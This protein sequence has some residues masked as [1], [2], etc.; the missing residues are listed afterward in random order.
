M[1]KF[2]TS[3]SDSQVARQRSAS[4]RSA[5]TSQSRANSTLEEMILQE[6]RAKL[7]KEQM[8]KKHEAAQYSDSGCSGEGSPEQEQESGSGY[9]SMNTSLQDIPMHHGKLSRGDSQYMDMSAS[10]YKA[11]SDVTDGDLDFDTTSASFVVEEDC[12]KMESYPKLADVPY[13]PWGEHEV[14]NVLREGRAKRYSCNITVEMMQR[15]S[16]MLQRPLTRIAREARRLSHT[17]LHCTKHEIQ[18]AMKVVLSCS[19]YNS[20]IQ[21]ASRAIA[22]HTVSP[23]C[24]KVSKSQRSGLKFS[25]GKFHRWMI[26]VEVAAVVDEQAAVCLAGCMENLLEEI[27]LRALQRQ[28]IGKH[29]ICCM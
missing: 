17:F 13:A 3:V 2:K 24:L 9:S 27:V 20:G 10:V 19:M 26:D 12:M 11:G 23:T 7:V 18:T 8:R 5:H 25:V 22:L 1:L 28:K 14:L 4:V 6:C 21:A 29:I 16:H 15:L